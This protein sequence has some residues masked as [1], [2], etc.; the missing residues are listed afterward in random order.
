MFKKVSKKI[1]SQDDKIVWFFF[2]TGMTFLMMI[3]L[4]F[5]VLQNTDT[6]LSQPVISEYAAGPKIPYTDPLISDAKIRY[7]KVLVDDARQGS[8]NAKVTIFF[9]CDLLS[10]LCQDQQGEINK[11]RTIYPE[12]EL[13]VVWKGTAATSEGFLAQQ[14]TYC[15]NV[16]GKFWEYQQIVF[17]EQK[18]ITVQSLEIIA[19]DLSLDMNEFN[20]CVAQAQM[21]EKVYQNNIEASDLGIDALPYFFID[22]TPYRG[23]FSYQELGNIIDTLTL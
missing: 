11:L 4:L 7:P 8:T 1:K 2:A 13:R 16:Q 20:T 21:E 23:F 12:T 5:F 17:N 22:N 18:N 3:F 15:A 14:A 6:N 19:Q 9:Y 10:P